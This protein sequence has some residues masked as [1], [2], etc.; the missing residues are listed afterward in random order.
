MKSVIARNPSSRAIF[1]LV[2]IICG[3]SVPA[4]N[5]AASERVVRSNAP[6]GNAGMV[7]SAH[8]LATL[9]GVEVLEQG[10]N[11]FDATV[12]VAATLTVVEPTS[13]NLFGG[14]GTLI[15]YD[16]EGGKLRYLDNN[17]RFP[18]AT[19]A[20]VFRQA[21]DPNSM[22]RT[23]QAVSTPGNL[24]GFETL[25][26]EFGTQPWEDLLQTATRLAADG[27][28]V[29]PP[30][31]RSLRD[32]WKYLSAYPKTFYGKNGRPLETGDVLVQKDLADSF[33]ATARQGAAALYGGLLGQKLDAA[34]KRRNGFLAMEDLT[35][36]RA[37]WF[38][39]ISIDYRDYQLVTAGPPSNSFAALLAAG[40]MSQFDNRALGSNTAPYL[41]RLAETSKHAYGARLRYAGGPETNP[42][43]LD[44]LLSHAYWKRQAG[45]VDF[46]RAT[47]FVPPGPLATEGQDTTHFVVADRWGN[48]VSAT[49]TL[50]TAFGSTVMVEGTGIWLNNSLAYCTFFPPGNAMDALPGNR[51]HSSKSPTIIMKDGRPWAAIGT[52]GGHTIP[53][54][55]PQ[56]AINLIDFEMDIQQSLD[57]P[58][59]AFS[60]PDKLLLDE[61]I[62]PEV[63]SQLRALGHNVQLKKAVGLPHALRIDFDALGKPTHFVGAADRYGV[64]K[65]IGLN[66]APAE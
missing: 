44:R 50:G 59:I 32:N 8:E 64:G 22:S 35:R 46:D 54:T 49:I 21:N 30:L 3:F 24:L 48:V 6:V 37:E 18:R 62:S 38:P 31:A 41:H 20:D 45:L 28:S 11:A 60:E 66:V 10:G 57:T 26:K 65:A 53:Q 27:V 9:A 1:L 5:V 52:P 63:Q 36:H 47:A 14:Y 43:P 13:S 16:A 34:M 29:S 19:D 39:P 55:V 33:R 58:R 23:A 25:W 4:V 56:M 61:R 17:G 7:S 12:A 51:K 40:I 15:V 2:S 42:P